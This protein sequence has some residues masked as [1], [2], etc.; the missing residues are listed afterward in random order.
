[1]STEGSALSCRVARYSLGALAYEM[2]T[3]LPPY[4]TQEKKT[5]RQVRQG[6]LHGRL[7]IFCFDFFRNVLRVL[8]RFS[9]V[10]PGF[11]WGSPGFCGFL[12]DFLRFSPGVL[13][14][15][16]FSL[17]FSRFLWVSPGSPQISPGFLGFLW[18][19]LWFLLFRWNSPMSIPS[20]ANSELSGVN[21]LNS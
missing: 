1:M 7:G 13:G 9:R 21:E 14:C 17:G 4:Y 18:Q 15:L 3:G 10:S 5:E 16:P 19:L 11:P 6:V 8:F 20:G 2:L 12:R